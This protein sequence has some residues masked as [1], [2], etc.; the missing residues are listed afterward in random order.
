MTIVIMFKNGKELR[1]KCENV[2][3]KRSCYDNEIFSLKFTKPTENKPIELDFKEIQCIYRVL[4][5][6]EV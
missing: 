2:S 3:V 5:D 6:E 4:S 1:I